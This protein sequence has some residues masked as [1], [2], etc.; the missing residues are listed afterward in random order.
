[1]CAW[2]DRVTAQGEPQ[3]GAALLW[4]SPPSRRSRRAAACSPASVPLWSVSSPLPPLPQAS[5]LAVPLAAPLA[6]AG[7]TVTWYLGT[8]SVRIS[9]GAGCVSHSVKTVR[10]S[11]VFQALAPRCHTSHRWLRKCPTCRTRSVLSC[12]HAALLTTIDLIGS[13]LSRAQVCG[14]PTAKQLQQ[15]LAWLMLRKTSSR[16]THSWRVNNLCLGRHVSQSDDVVF[17]VVLAGLK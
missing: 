2:K 10:V 11:T 15:L 1:M 5:P 14:S 16:G 9:S 3:V 12:P 13:N 6:A 8:R 4:A 7:A 17:V